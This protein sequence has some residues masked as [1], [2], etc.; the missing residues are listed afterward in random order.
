MKTK[1]LAKLLELMDEQTKNCFEHPTDRALFHL[2][3]R[4]ENE[5]PELDG[6]FHKA[7]RQTDVTD[8]GH[9]DMA[10]WCLLH[11]SKIFWK[12]FEQMQPEKK[13]KLKK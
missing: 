8:S 9:T 11:H 6:Y 7:F 4:W 12:L 2:L 3:K 1:K 10:I 13:T 5:L